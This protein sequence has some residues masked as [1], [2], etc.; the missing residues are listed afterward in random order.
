MGSWGYISD[1]RAFAGREQS[2]LVP[3]SW[4]G[5]LGSPGAHSSCS[6]AHL[7]LQTG[8]P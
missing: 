2:P 4:K 5:V 7:H 1:P 3:P 6:Q 8:S